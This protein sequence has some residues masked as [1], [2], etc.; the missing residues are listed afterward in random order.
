MSGVTTHVNGLFASPLASRFELLHFQIG[1]EGRDEG[2]AGKLWRLLASPFQLAAAIVRSDAAVVH[3]NTS[4]DARGYWRDLAYLAVAKA[5]G[6][7]V[8]YQIHDNLFRVLDAARG[9]LAF[10]LNVAARWPDAVIVLS[11]REAEAWTARGG[12]ERLRAVPNGIDCA[13]FLRQ[14]RTREAGPLRLIYVGRLAPRKGLL[15]SL[16]ALRLARGR[17][18]GARLVIAG[19]GPEE[20]RLRH[21]VRDFGLVRDVTFVGPAYGEHKARLLAQADILLLPSYSEGLPYA[22]LEAMASGVV[23]VVTPVGAVPEVVNDGEH[24]VFVE[25]RDAAAI[26]AAIE[27]LAGDRAGVLRMSAACR[28]R[29]A[30]GYSLE[31]LARDFSGIYGALCQASVPKAVL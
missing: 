29:A 9:S 23:P 14:N 6:A 20:A 16:E 1:S 2:A 26:A 28:R 24:G 15:E 10:G 19:G 30:L 25:P 7:R 21:Y 3:I 22:L 31:R 8:V 12:P 18:I 27:A 11:Q 17:G 5:F 13:P 4:L